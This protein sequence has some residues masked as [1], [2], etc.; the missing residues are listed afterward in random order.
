MSDFGVA[1]LAIGRNG[2]LQHI[3]AIGLEP[4]G[5]HHAVAAR[6][7]SGLKVVLEKQ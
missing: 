4:L 6:Q 1:R 2:L 3:G 5:V 7:G